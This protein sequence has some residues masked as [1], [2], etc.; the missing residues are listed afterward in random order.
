MAV[1]WVA[2]TEHNLAEKWVFQKADLWDAMSDP[3]SVGKK[4][5]QTVAMKDLMRAGR[6]EQPM[7]ESSVADLAD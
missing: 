7:A 4:G 3:Q 6:S 2:Q 1:G 5:A